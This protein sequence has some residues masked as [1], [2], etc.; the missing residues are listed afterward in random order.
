[1][2]RERNIEALRQ[3]LER[4][5]R[6]VEQHHDAVTTLQTQM[7]SYVRRLDALE[8]RLRMVQARQSGH[9]AT[10]REQ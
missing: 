8:D 6:Q 4:L 9:G 3:A 1:M 2:T 7:T 10:K 5:Q